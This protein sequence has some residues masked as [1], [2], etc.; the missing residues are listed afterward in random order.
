MLRCSAARW[1]SPRSC[2]SAATLVGNPQDVLIGQ[3]L[4][5]SFNAYFAYAA[6]PT[7]LELT[8]V[9]AVI[10]VQQRGDRRAPVVAGEATLD[11]NDATVP[12]DGWQTAKGL[13]VAAAFLLSRRL[14]SRDKLGLVDWPLLVV[15]LGTLVA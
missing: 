3:T 5:L 13:A 14:H 12:F 2:G 6:L 1:W 9:W 8:V 10:A 7:A 15:E 11:A 4:A